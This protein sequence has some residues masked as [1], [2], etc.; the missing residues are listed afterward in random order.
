VICSALREHA[1]KSTKA[2]LDAS[3]ILSYITSA[4]D[5]TW[6]GTSHALILHWEDQ[7]RCYEKQVE[8]S[9][10][11]LPGVKKVMLQNAV[12]PITELR[13][14]KVQADQHRTQTGDDLDYDQYVTLLTSAANNYDAQFRSKSKTSVQRRTVYSHELLED[15]EDPIEPIDGAYDIDIGVDTIQANFTSRIGKDSPSFMP[16]ERWMKLL[17]LPPGERATWNK[18]SPE[19]KAIILGS[20]STGFRSPSLDARP[21]PNI[22]P[23]Q[24]KVNFSDLS[25]GDRLEVYR[26]AMAMELLGGASPGDGEGPPHQ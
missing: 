1:S 14:V 12:H 20:E 16:K 22:R 23:P 25:L 10:H 9:D 21:A 7:V 26:H 2:A 5:G 19:A 11:F 18:L 13:A 17:Q 3:D 6:K 4:R 15:D 24:R 8:K